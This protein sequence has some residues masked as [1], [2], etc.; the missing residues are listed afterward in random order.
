MNILTQ[1][2]NYLPIDIETKYQ[3]CCQ[4]TNELRDDQNIELQKNLC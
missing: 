4:L 2:R 1:E 3:C